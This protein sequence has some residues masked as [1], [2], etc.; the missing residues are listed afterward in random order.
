MA[1]SGSFIHLNTFAQRSP[2]IVFL[3]LS[4]QNSELVHIATLIP[5]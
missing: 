3:S 2:D 4:L 1:I 5:R